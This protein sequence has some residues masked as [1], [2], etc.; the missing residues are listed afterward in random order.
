MWQNGCA[1]VE[2]FMLNYT[3][4]EV[5]MLNYNAADMMYLFFI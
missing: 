2:V 5:F 1:V 4:V 3:V